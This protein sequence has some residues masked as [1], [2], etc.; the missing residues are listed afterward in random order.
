M[1]ARLANWKDGR[2]DVKAAACALVPKIS[3]ET[4]PDRLTL[5][6][7]I[8]MTITGCLKAVETAG[9]KVR[10]DDKRQLLLFDLGLPDTLT[11]RNDGKT[12]S[13]DTIEMT[14]EDYRFAV[15]ERRR[16]IGA[17]TAALQ[18]MEDVLTLVEPLMLKDPKMR[19]GDALLLAYKR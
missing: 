10:P 7:V 9:A 1:K 8:Q 4:D 5:D 11:V 13:V 14:L 6:E 19:L 16:Q 2:A 17:D 18:P 3:V 12:E 15:F